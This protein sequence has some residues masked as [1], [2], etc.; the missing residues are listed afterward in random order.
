MEELTEVIQKEELTPV[1]ERLTLTRASSGYV[2]LNSYTT[3]TFFNGSDEPDKMKIPAKWSKKVG[4]IK[5]FYKH[6]PIISTVIDKSVDIGINEIYNDQGDAPDNV[7]E[8]YDFFK[9][10]LHAFLKYMAR[11]YLLSGLVVPEVNWTSKEIEIPSGKKVVTLPD[12]MWLRDPATIV[13]KKTPIPNRINYYIEVDADTIYFILNNGINVD[14]TKD[15]E[16][17]K[18]L[19]NDFPDFVKRVKAGE[20]TVPLPNPFSIITRSQ[21]PGEVYPTPYLYSV[22]EPLQYKRKLRKMDYAVAAR[23]IGAIQVIKIGNN[24]FPISGEDGEQQIAD[25]RAEMRNRGDD[26]ERIFQ[27]Y[28]NH[29]LDI[30]WVFPDTKAMLDKGKYDIVNQD[31]MFGLGFPRILLSGE[32]EKSATSNPEF[33]MFSPSES[34]RAM[35]NDLLPFVEKLYK[36]IA[37]LNG[38]D[39]YPTLE[40]ASLRLFDVEKMAEIIKLLM[41][42]ASLSKTSALKSAG[43]EFDK[44]VQNI[45]REREIM[46]ENDIPEFQAQPF[47]PQPTVPGKT[48]NQPATTKKVKKDGI[49]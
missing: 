17:F 44:E 49:N 5:F 4:L 10:K 36:E 40:F 33:A 8:V 43:F 47:S 30:S 7:L 41:A 45:V 26:V 34:L 14:G 1:V 23:T 13:V 18:I 21:I 48:P 32:T 6:D 19:K 22:L 46:E 39:K 20:T 16:T 38:F 2:D 15:L 9:I 27:V 31:I 12:V 3:S 37:R 42:G 24:E 28:G 35:R 25:L 11:E 29:T